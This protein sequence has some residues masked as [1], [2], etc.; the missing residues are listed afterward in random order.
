MSA[1]RDTVQKMLDEAM[2]E[3]T[4]LHG[5]INYLRKKLGLEVLPSAVSDGKGAQN[6]GLKPDSFFGHT[7]G[8]AIEKYLKI[9]KEP[10]GFQEISDALQAGG[11][12]HNSKNLATTVNGVLFRYGNGK[13][14]VV[15][16]PTGQW[17]LR[18]W[19][20]NLKGSKGGGAAAEEDE[21]SEDES[22]PV[23]TEKPVKGEKAKA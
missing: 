8:A 17:G 16:L 18:E 14:V 4:A 10:K 23:E 9:V 5:H 7:I 15:R 20:P 11:L 3:Y 6:Q 1:E 12:E 22:E 19:Y 21:S 2:S 13:K